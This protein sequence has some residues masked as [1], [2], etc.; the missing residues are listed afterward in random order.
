MNIS[1]IDYMED[2]YHQLVVA[3]DYVIGWIEAQPRKQRTSEMAADMFYKEVIFRI[4][5]LESVVLDRGAENKKCT[6]LLF[7]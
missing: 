2:R 4:G 6:D 3:K 7:K 5:T 1:Y